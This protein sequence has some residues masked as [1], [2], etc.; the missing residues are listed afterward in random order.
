MTDPFTAW[1]RIFA[2]GLD[3]QSTWLRCVETMQASRSVIGV[4][5]D[6]MRGMPRPGDPAEY[7]RMV[8]EKVEAF[9]RSAQAVMRDA[10]AMQHAWTVQMQRVGMMML[11]GR[12]PTW[13]EAATLAAQSGDYALGV[14]TASAQMGKGALAPVH[15]AATGNAR[16]LKRARTR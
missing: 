15:R 2:A 14:V 12:L 13:S 16:R 3:M 4:R 5:T 1:S 10:M 8:P 6:M 7:A 9:S 11:G